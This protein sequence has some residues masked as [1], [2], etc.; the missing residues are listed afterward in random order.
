M[1]R[2]FHPQRH[3]AAQGGF[4]LIELMVALAIIAILSAVAVP[5]Y[6]DQMTRSRRADAKGALQQAA[7]WMERNQTATYRYDRDAGG[8]A[9]DA[10][11][12][13]QLGL[14]QTPATGTAVYKLT[15][16]SGPSTSAYVLVATPQ[17]SQAT[18]DAACGTLAIDNIGQR[19][20]LSGTAVVIDS[21][22]EA[23]WQR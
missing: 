7:M 16:A 23:C 20:R 17:G 2:R 5:A 15:F 12:L 10:A 13:A 4:S 9:V 18:V 3:S 1:T 11:Y 6:R 8:T 21:T 14:A 22:S 19:G